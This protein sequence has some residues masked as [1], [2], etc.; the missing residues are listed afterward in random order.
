MEKDSYEIIREKFLSL[1]VCSNIPPE[2]K[3]TLNKM[4]NSTT[5]CGT[6]NGWMLENEITPVRCAERKDHWHYIFIC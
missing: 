2:R 6:T 4:V 5:L 1:Q 3:E